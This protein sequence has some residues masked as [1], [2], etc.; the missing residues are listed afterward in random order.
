MI[1]LLVVP[2]V[3]DLSRATERAFLAFDYLI[4]AVFAAEYAIKLYLAP[5]RRR[6]VLHHLPDLIIVIVPMLRPLRVL[7]SAR[8]LR[9]FRLTRLVAFAVEGLGEA[10]GILRHHGLNWVLLIVLA[11]NLIAAAAVAR[12]RTRQPRGEHPLLP[13]RA[14]VGGN[15]HHHGR[16]R[17]PF[18][19][20]TSR[21][22]CRSRPDD[23]RHRIVRDHHRD[24]RHL[25]RRTEGRG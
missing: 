8:L 18:P 11:L 9:L 5:N 17:R 25:L 15:H 16:L 22:R 7:R 14:V 6:F 10:R 3:V 12:I 19:D 24:D 23:R 21:S 1:P 20:V 2:L 13:G 4:W